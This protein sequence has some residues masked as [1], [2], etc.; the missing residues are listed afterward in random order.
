MAELNDENNRAINEE[1][2]FPNPAYVA[3]HTR[4]RKTRPTHDYVNLPSQSIAGHSG[5]AQDVV[6]REQVNTCMV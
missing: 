4:T 1:Q 6:N 2:L 5:K 3:I